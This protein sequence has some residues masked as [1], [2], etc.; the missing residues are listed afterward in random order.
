MSQIEE[1]ATRP[2]TARP[3]DSL[4]AW[5]R[6]LRA[7]AALTR[8]LS[9][10]LVAGHGLTI[11]DYEALL[12]LSR[13]PGNLMRR[14]DLAERVLLTA[15]GITRL[16]DGLEVAGLVERAGCPSDRRV[17]YAKLTRAGKQKLREA[18]TTHLAGIAEL[19]TGRYTDSELETLASLLGRLPGASSDDGAECAP[20]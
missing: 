4:E 20:D 8:E 9:A 5:V 18:S 16:L 17:V 7:H 2:R 10:D 12:H 19:F 13:A 6:F 14:V 1:R 15:S 3:S 11:N